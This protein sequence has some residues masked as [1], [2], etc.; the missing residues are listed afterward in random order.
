MNDKTE[1]CGTPFVKCIVMVGLSLSSGHAWLPEINLVSLH[2]KSGSM[3]ALRIFEN[4][5]VIADGCSGRNS[6]NN[7]SVHDDNGKDR[8]EGN[9]GKISRGASSN[10]SRRISSY[11]FL[12]CF[13]RLVRQHFLQA[14]GRL[15]WWFRPHSRD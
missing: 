10:E 4:E 13:C 15:W 6:S 12:R 1:P 14:L 9:S 11:G 8:S 2:L 3:L 7:V 5:L